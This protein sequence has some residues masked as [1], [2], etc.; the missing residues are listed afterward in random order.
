MMMTATIMTSIMPTIKATKYSISFW[1]VVKP[2]FGALV[3]FAIY[4]LH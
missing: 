2:V 4:K 3:S 1:S